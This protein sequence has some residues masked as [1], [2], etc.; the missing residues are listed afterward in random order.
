MTTEE[1]KIE[2][3][4]KSQEGVLNGSLKFAFIKGAKSDA[5]KE[6]HTKGMY[7]QE[8]LDERLDLQA[9][10]TTSQV[11]KNIG[12]MMITKEEVLSFFEKYEPNLAVTI[13]KS[14][15]VEWFEQ[16]KTV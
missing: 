8:Q 13:L 7:T 14:E 6:Y 9:C 1:K 5:A 11:I 2:E 15:F 16:N 3:A 4:A 10:E 12:K